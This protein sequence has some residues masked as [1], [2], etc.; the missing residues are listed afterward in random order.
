MIGMPKPTEGIWEGVKYKWLFFWRVIFRIFSNI[1]LIF[2][3]LILIYRI[4][5]YRNISEINKNI[6]FSVVA[7][8]IYLFVVNSLFVTYSVVSG[9][10]EIILPDG[11]PE[12]KQI[13]YL[14]L[15]LIPLNGVISLF[16]YLIG[17]AMT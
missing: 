12:Y 2:V 17:L 11:V 1:W 7:F 15:H 16:Q 9:Q 4:L 6:V 5:K 8:L 14:F 10:T 3:P 13:W